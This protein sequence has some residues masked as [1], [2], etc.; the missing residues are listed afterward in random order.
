MAIPCR[1]VLP[2]FPEKCIRAEDQ[3]A[4][5]KMRRIIKV[6]SRIRV[7]IQR[8]GRCLDGLD[9]TASALGGCLGT[10][11]PSYPYYRGEGQIPGRMTRRHSGAFEVARTV[12]AT[13]L[14]GLVQ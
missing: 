3:E 13:P 10:W 6:C 5:K 7:T 1:S 9:S 2:G 4:L 8:S 12:G 14:T 11:S